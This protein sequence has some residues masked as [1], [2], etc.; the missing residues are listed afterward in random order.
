MSSLASSITIK[1]DQENYL[2]WRAQFVPALYG[3]GLMGFVDGTYPAPPESLPGS[4]E[5]GAP[6]TVPNPAYAG[7][8]RQDQQVLSA[9]LAS[10]T[11]G[12][13]GHVLFM[14]TAAEAWEALEQMFA[15]RSKARI[16]QLRVQ[17]ATVQ[18]GDLSMAEY[19]HRM[20]N[21]A[22]TMA[23]M[24]HRPPT[25]R[26]GVRLL[27]PRRPRQQLRRPRHFAHI[28]LRRLQHRRALR[29]PHQL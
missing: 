2:L 4:K 26:P 27:R 9:I 15:S 14:T 1:L 21:L 20:K 28:S 17:L 29:P 18:K 6:K 19:F 25:W 5:E 22:D 24:F 16:V 23:S 13:L 7:L 3:H 12:L 11:P 8:F 10:L